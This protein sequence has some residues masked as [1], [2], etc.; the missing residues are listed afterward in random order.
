MHDVGT[1]FAV[2]QFLE[3]NAYHFHNFGTAFAVPKYSRH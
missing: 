2:P 3:I 1:A